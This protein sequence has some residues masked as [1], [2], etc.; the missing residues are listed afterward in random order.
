MRKKIVAP[1]KVIEKKRPLKFRTEL[2]G[3]CWIAHGGNPSNSF[4]LFDP[5]TNSYHAWSNEWNIWYPPLAKGP[6]SDLG[7]CPV[8]ERH[9]PK[10]E[11][12]MMLAIRNRSKEYA[13]GSNLVAQSNRELAL[14]MKRFELSEQG[15]RVSEKNWNKCLQMA[16]DED[17]FERW[18]AN[19]LIQLIQEDDG[20]DRL[21]RLG[22]WLK[23]TEHVEREEVQPHYLRF[24]K[25]VEQAAT[26]AGGV[27]FQKSVKTIYEKE[28]TA[29]QLGQ[30]HGFRSVMEKLKFDWL[31]AGGRGK[32]L[33][34]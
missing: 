26:E 17:A 24:L 28:L 10:S 7:H 19:H 2:V 27:P 9:Q 18:V 22:E 14:R 34:R 25:A 33:K 6:Y 21:I 11:L 15:I 29:N 12:L 16:T 13:P 23:K 5:N 3:P 31:P 30:G 20:A 8:N 1:K 4:L 32:S